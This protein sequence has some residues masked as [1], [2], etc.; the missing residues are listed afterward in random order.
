MPY[1]QKVLN[2]EVHLRNS[3]PCKTKRDQTA[4]N[5]RF[6]FLFFYF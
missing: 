3:N 2:N 5:T 4:L 1:Y 6:Q